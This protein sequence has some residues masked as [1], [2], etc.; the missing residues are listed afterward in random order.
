MANETTVPTIKPNT[1]EGWIKLLDAVRLPVPQASHDRVCKAIADSRSSMRDIAELM[2]ESPA[3][4]LSVIREANQH[5]HGSMTEPAEN[6]EVA[7]NRLGLKRTEE[8]LARLPA[9]P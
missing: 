9:L 2:Q 8:L 4:A 7:I 5:T 3:L 1:L 6:L